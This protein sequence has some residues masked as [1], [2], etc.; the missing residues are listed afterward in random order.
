MARQPGEYELDDDD[1]GGD[2]RIAPYVPLNK[3]PSLAYYVQLRQ[4]RAWSRYPAMGEA[5]L[6]AAVSIASSSGAG[7][8]VVLTDRGLKGRQVLSLREPLANWA[9][10]SIVHLDLSRNRLRDKGVGAV[11]KVLSGNSSITRL[12]LEHNGIGDPG[13]ASLGDLLRKHG[14]ITDVNLRRN[15]FTDTGVSQYA[16]I[17]SARS[18]SL[19]RA[20][21]VQTI[22]I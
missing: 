8:E 14:S 6:Q 12:Q 3:S 18:L 9:A 22:L 4:G 2:G 11:V 20:R 17:N 19:A 21:S 10:A 5:E 15:V 16:G 13:A 1:D 7:G